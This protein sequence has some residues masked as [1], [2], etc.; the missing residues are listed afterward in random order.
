MIRKVSAGVS[1]VFGR[2]KNANQKLLDEVKELD[3]PWMVSKEFTG[4]RA[5]ICYETTR[6]TFRYFDFD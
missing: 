2:F 6:F 4:N 3:T 5:E 1:T